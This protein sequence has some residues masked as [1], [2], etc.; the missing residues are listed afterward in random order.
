MNISKPVS[1]VS[2]F[3]TRLGKLGFVILSGSVLLWALLFAFRQNAQNV[4]AAPID[5]PEG[6]PK[7]SMSALTVTPTL[8]GTSG[9]MLS[10]LI[11]IRNTGAYM[12]EGVTLSNTLP[13]EG[14]YNGDAQASS[15]AA[16]T[17]VSDT[18]LWAGDVGFDASVWISYSVTLSPGLP[19]T[20]R[21]T[22]VINHALI[23]QAVTV[24]AETVVT[25]SPI[26]T[27]TKQSAPAMPGAGKLLVYT[28]AV[29]NRG[30]LAANLPI[31]VTDYLPANTAFDNAGGGAFDGAK[32]TWTR[33]VTL[34]LGETSLFTF[35]VN[36][37][38]VLS[39]TVIT[40]SMYQVASASTGIAVARVD[41]GGVELVVSH[42]SERTLAWNLR[43]GVVG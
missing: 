4:H 9:E 25:D 6:Y 7:L 3:I 8:A 28:L 5:P 17:V 14:S 31:T 34:S 35:S 21:N 20:V 16:P 39:G 36:V 15:G 23:P 41:S 40:N 32:V 29:E 11:E 22:A 26:L 19:G 42:G 27:I 24:T 12:A 38:N 33:T 2:N 43:P 37:D 18:L 1:N 13:S 10:Y 30:Q